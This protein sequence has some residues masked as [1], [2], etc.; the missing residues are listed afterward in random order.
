MPGK[1]KSRRF[2]EFLESK[3][4][5]RIYKG[6]RLVFASQKDKLVPMV[7]YIESRAPYITDVTVYDRIVGNAA[8]LLLKTIRCRSVFSELGSENAIRTLK[9]AG[10][11]YRFNKTV[12]CI[13]NDSGKDMCPMERLSLGKTPDEFL[14]ALKE[15][16][17]RSNK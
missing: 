15:R 7:E 13:M 12:D 17:G 5:F 9:S 16:M 6:N 8:A 4:T 3:D 2:T 10:I 11:K 14:S 1:I